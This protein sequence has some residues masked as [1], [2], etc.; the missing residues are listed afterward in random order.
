MYTRTTVN[1]IYLWFD[2]QQKVQFDA[3]EI[4][5]LIAACEY[6]KNA[7][8]FSG[9][10][11]PAKSAKFM[12]KLLFED[13][14]W[15]QKKRIE[16]PYP[17]PGH[18]AFKYEF[19]GEHIWDLNKMKMGKSKGLTFGSPLFNLLH[20]GAIL[21]SKINKLRLQVIKD[22]NKTQQSHADDIKILF[23]GSKYNDYP[24]VK[25]SDTKHWMFMTARSSFG[26]TIRKLE[27]YAEMDG[28]EV[29]SVSI[30]QP[31]L[32][33]IDYKTEIQNHA[34]KGTPISL[35]SLHIPR[36]ND[37]ITN[38]EKLAAAYPFIAK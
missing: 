17:M 18:I 37:Y 26:K 33:L 29:V 38:S 8:L 22:H 14:K 23:G 27:E 28:M 20:H 30:P 12:Y 34:M 25:V 9:C 1:A 31:L 7:V 21:P 5:N 16:Y 3:I 35:Y 19:D 11:I 15:R 36:S 6:A 4:Q 2:R 32:I 24:M 10:L 13:Q